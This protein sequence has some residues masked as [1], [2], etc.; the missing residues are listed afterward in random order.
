MVILMPAEL[1]PFVGETNIPTVG[2][3]GSRNP[4][5]PHLAGTA[6]RRSQYPPADRL[7]AVLSIGSPSGSSGYRSA[8]LVARR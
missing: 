6:A 4:L 5:L 7:S 8:S 2:A 1:F 3:G